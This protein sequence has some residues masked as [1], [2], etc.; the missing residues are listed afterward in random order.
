MRKRACDNH[1]INCDKSDQAALE[2][3]CASGHPRACRSAATALGAAPDRAGDDPPPPADDDSGSVN[4]LSAEGTPGKQDAAKQLAMYQRA[5]GEDELY[6]CEQAGDAL[7]KTDAKRALV[8]HQK[9][10]D[11]EQKIPALVRPICTEL[12]ARFDAGTGVAKDAAKAKTLRAQG[13]KA[14][15]KKAC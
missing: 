8:L 15:E 11:L 9:S 6:G 5:C 2:K 4:M 12:G 1:S 14:G 13:C 3:Q 7:W 10:C